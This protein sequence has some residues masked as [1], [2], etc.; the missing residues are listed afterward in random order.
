MSKYLCNWKSNRI[1]LYHQE[2]II[3]GLNKYKIKANMRKKILKKNDLE[4]FIRKN[5]K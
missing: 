1:I 3:I 2:Y 5:E 4:N